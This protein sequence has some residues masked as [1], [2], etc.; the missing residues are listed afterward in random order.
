MNDIAMLNDARIHAEN[1][2]AK[3]ESLLR[4]QGDDIEKYFNKN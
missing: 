3:A 4:L 1:E 2:L